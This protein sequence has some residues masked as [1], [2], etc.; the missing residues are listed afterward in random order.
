MEAPRL[1]SFFKSR[2]PQGF[3]FKPRYYDE[4]KEKHQKL[5]KENSELPSDK[6]VQ[7]FR[8]QWQNNRKYSPKGGQLIR[9]AVILAAL[10]LTAWWLLF[11]A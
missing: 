8:S 7:G 1:P 6:R 10:S 9:L 2:R 11:S 4:L 5:E 3:D